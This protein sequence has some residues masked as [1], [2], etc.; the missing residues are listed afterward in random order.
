MRTF[1]F[2]LASHRRDRYKPLGSGSILGRG[3]HAVVYTI[4]ASDRTFNW[5]GLPASFACAGLS[6]TYQPSEQR[7]WTATLERAGTA[8]LGY[9]FG[10]L[11]LEFTQKEIQDRARLRRLVK[12]R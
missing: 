2:A 1:V 10:N 12:S 5:S 11:W 9:L 6:N 4:M 3:W 8:T 7:T